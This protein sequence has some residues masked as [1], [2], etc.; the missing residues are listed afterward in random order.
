MYGRCVYC[1]YPYALCRCVDEEDDMNQ[2]DTR[3][4][5]IKWTEKTLA[6]GRG[7]LICTSLA[8]Q[9][10]SQLATVVLLDQQMSGVATENDSTVDRKDLCASGP[11][12]TLLQGTP[13]TESRRIST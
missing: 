4:I 11:E 13:F 2:E 9:E 6:C 3:Q 8:F 10:S 12:V 1:G 7:V 5:L